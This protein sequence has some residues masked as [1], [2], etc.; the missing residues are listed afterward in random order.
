MERFRKTFVLILFSVLMAASLFAEDEVVII[1]EITCLGNLD[2]S[3]PMLF[4]SSTVEEMKDSTLNAVTSVHD[5]YG[6]EYP[7]NLSFMR[8]PGSDNSWLLIASVGSDLKWTETANVRV[9]VG[10]SDGVMGS[11]VL[12]FYREGNLFSIVDSDGTIAADDGSF[13]LT[14]SFEF[15][16]EK[17]GPVTPQFFR[18]NLAS[19]DETL[20]LTSAETDFNFTKELKAQAPV[21]SD[22]IEEVEPEFEETVDEKTATEAVESEPQIVETAPEPDVAASIPETKPK[23]VQRK[24]HPYGFQKSPLHKPKGKGSWWL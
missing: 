16:D 19:G 10:T 18:L 15:V 3:T 11:V 17:Y 13:A 8:V 6:A 7:L 20:T 5:F 22:E 24:N 23:K 1:E 4:D 9:G 12:Y 21:P 14:C 2:S